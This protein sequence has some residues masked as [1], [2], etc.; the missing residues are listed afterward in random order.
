MAICLKFS[1]F[2]MRQPYPTPCLP[3]DNLVNVTYSARFLKTSLSI[4]KRSFK[5]K[6]SKNR[7]FEN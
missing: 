5:V 4:R 7:I 2:N 3:L 1:T 6:T